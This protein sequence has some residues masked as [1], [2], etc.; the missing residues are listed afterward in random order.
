MPEN[1]LNKLVAAYRRD[2]AGRDLIMEKVATLVYEGHKRFGFDDEDDAANAMLK[3]RSR[4]DRLVDRFEDRGLPFDVYLAANLK[5]LARTARRERRKAREREETCE[6]AVLGESIAAAG[7]GGFASTDIGAS[8][9]ARSSAPSPVGLRASRRRPRAR[10]GLVPHS[11]AEAAAYST[12]LVFL[13]VKCAWEIDET[14]ISRVAASAG[15]EREW[16][17]AAI[18]QARRSMESDRDR[19]ERLTQRRNASWTRLLLLDGRLRE[20][21][22]PYRK[23]K[24]FASKRRE[25]LRFANVA[26]EI[27]AL[28]PIVPNSLVAR[29]L[30]LPKGTVDSGLYYLRKRFSEIE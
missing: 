14:G 17:A 25:S 23:A 27:S 7:G 6:R 3:F 30:G 8:L 24:L 22:D 18:E 2:G 11:A 5:Y 13:A 1:D 28:R 20:E 10:G 15:V 12:R 19:V 21:A 16:L 9:E 29:I 26:A 4:I